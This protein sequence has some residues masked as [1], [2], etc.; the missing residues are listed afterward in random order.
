MPRT[1]RTRRLLPPTGL[2]PKGDDPLTTGQ[3]DRALMLRAT[4]G[5]GEV[6]GGRV[7]FSFHGES[8]TFDAGA[9][10]AEADEECSSAIR[11]MPN[12]RNASCS[13]GPISDDRVADFVISLHRYR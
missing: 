6:L 8:A 5:K 9:G 7:T 11:S 4:A 12:V 2:C 10:R 1:R 13:R 3:P